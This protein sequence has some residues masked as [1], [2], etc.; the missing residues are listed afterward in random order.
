M[1]IVVIPGTNYNN[2]PAGFSAAVDYVVNLFDNLYTAN[3]TVYINVDYGQIDSTNAAVPPLGKSNWNLNSFS[4]STIR[5]TLINMGAPGSNT[6]PA[7]SPFGGTL[8]LT[9]AQQK[10][11]G[12]LPATFQP[13]NGYPY[14]GAMSVLQVMQRCKRTAVLLGASLRLQLRPQISITSSARS[15]M[16]SR[17]CWAEILSMEPTPSIM[18]PAIP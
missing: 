3:V 2:A 15:N 1:H 6:L 17:K 7:A 5:Q 4:Y 11:L 12:L 14:P 13:G 18:R 9:T 10:A 8:W 16:N